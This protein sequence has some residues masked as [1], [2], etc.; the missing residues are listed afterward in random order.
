MKFEFV[1]RFLLAL[2]YSLFYLFFFL[3]FGSFHLIGSY[4]IYPLFLCY[5]QRSIKTLSCIFKFSSQFWVINS[6]EGTILIL[7]C[8]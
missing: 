8:Y 3:F 2:I 1:L 5:L 4:M 6:V 7:G